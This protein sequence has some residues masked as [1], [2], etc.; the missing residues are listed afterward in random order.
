MKK[1]E[2]ISHF[3]AHQQNEQETQKKNIEICTRVRERLI[4]KKQRNRVE[5][6]VP[7][8]IPQEVKIS[9]RLPVREFKV[10]KRKLK[11][12]LEAAYAQPPVVKTSKIIQEEIL[13]KAKEF[14]EVTKKVSQRKKIRIHPVN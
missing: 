13:A 1:K 8:R 10:P 7:E 4:S 9:K 5:K 6:V 3:S 14:R 2:R 12:H 11:F